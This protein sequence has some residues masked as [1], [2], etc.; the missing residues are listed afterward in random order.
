MIDAVGCECRGCPCHG[1]TPIMP[2]HVRAR[3]LEVV[4]DAH[5]I[6]REEDD[7]IIVDSLRLVAGA[8]T[9]LVRNDDLEAGVDERRNLLRPQALGVGEAVQQHDR[10]PLTF[11]VHVEGDA[12]HRDSHV[13]PQDTRA[14]SSSR[15]GPG[16]GSSRQPPPSS[17]ARAATPGRVM[18]S[19]GSAW[20]VARSMNAL[21]ISGSLPAALISDRVNSYSS[22]VA[23]CTP[24][25][26][27]S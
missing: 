2:H 15:L 10:P 14:S 21:S 19:D 16:S 5:Y 1:R 7:R 24:C 11:H 22:S 4:E 9:A 20:T 6:E 12:I 13:P 17:S 3:D 25:S 26:A 27:A 8:V 18:T 23:N